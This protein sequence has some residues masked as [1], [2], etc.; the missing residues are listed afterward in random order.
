MKS[1]THIT[2][3]VLKCTLAKGFDKVSRWKSVLPHTFLTTKN[4][5]FRTRSDL[6][7]VR[8]LRRRRTELLGHSGLL[9]CVVNGKFGGFIQHSI[10]AES[11]LNDRRIL[12]KAIRDDN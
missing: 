10:V 1:K 4:K 2:Q 9:A 5:F 7:S 11:L 12:Q 6:D 8:H 3:D